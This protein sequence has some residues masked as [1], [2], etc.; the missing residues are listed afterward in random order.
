MRTLLLI[1]AMLCMLPACQTVSAIS[2]P[3]LRD[4]YDDDLTIQLARAA[5]SGNTKRMDTLISKGADVNHVGKEGMTPLMWALGKKSKSGM[6]YLL[7]RGANPNVPAKR[8]LSVTMLTAG[9]EDTE[10]L[11]M[12]LAHGG[13]P[14]YVNTSTDVVITP[15]F[16]AIDNANA[17]TAALLIRAGAD[18]NYNKHMSKMTPMMDAATLNQ[19]KIVY[20]LLEAGADYSITNSW[21]KTIAWHINEVRLVKN[22][23][24]QIWHQKCVEFLRERGFEVSPHPYFD[25]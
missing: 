6:R 16:M 11:E 13:D 23:E 12:V 9:I 21:N 19:W 7:E 8:G 2:G 17:A 24:N 1:L 25:K 14:N 18:L 5:A 15:L 20:L 10:Y 22:S 4:F 3:S